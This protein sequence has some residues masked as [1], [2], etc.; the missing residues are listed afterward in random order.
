MAMGVEIERKFLILRKPEQ[1]PDRVHKI[2]QG[3][4]AR[5]NSNSVR[6]RQKDGDFILSIKTNHAAGGRNELEYGITAEEGGILFASISHAAIIKVREVYEI[7]DHTW[8]VDIFEGENKGL[9]IAEVELGSKDEH[10]TLPDWIGPEVTDMG[11][12]YNSN[13]SQ[14]PFKNWNISYQALVERM[15]G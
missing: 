11:K 6:V 1:K 4:I 3:Y 7:G 2:R 13:I 5:E 15:S 12:F 9:I 8:E 14:M 10:V